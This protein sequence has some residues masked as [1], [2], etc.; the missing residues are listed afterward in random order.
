M[1]EGYVEVE[2]SADA[3]LAEHLIAVLTQVGFEGFW[4][5]EGALRCYLR[6]A[7]CTPD[8]LQEVRTLTILVARSSLSPA[9]VIRTRTLP[10]KNWN[11]EWEKTIGPLRVTDRI[12]ITPSWHP[13]VEGENDLVLTIDPKMSFGTG[14]HESTRLALRLLEPLVRPGMHL[15]DVGTGTGVLAIAGIKLGCNSAVGCDIDEW[16]FR[17]ASEN[18]ERNGVGERVTILQGDLGAVPGSAFDLVLAN[19]HLKVLV[20]ILPGLRARL[21]PGGAMILSGLLVADEEEMRR[22]LRDQTMD[23]KERLS[24]NE[25]LAFSC[26]LLPQERFRSAAP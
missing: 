5:D 10:E 26:T 6:A 12:I 25:W 16:A 22:A 18:A 23:V 9:P 14:Y 15:L 19:I 21:A 20:E 13:L 24:E 4:E 2:I 11:E 17:N 3:S 7:R 1:P 8:F